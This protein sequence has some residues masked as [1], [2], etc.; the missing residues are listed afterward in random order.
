MQKVIINGRFLSQ[1]VTGVQRYA[2]EI[3]KELDKIAK[4]HDLILAIPCEVNDIPSYKN[5]DIVRIGNLKGTLWEQISFSSFVRKKKAIALNLCNSA[6]LLNPGIVT[7]HDVKIKAYPQFFSSKFRIWYN[8]LF[9]NEAKR[10]KVIITVSEFS[11]KEIGRYYYV[12][13]ENIHVVPNAWQHYTKINFD[14]NTLSRYGLEK[15]KFY[16]AM[17]SLEPNKNFKLIA[18]AAK[19]DSSQLFV[20][21]GSINERIFSNGVGFECPENIKLIGYIS[22]E[23]GKTLMRDSKAFLFPSFYEGFGIPPLE[24]L[25]AGCSSIIVSDIPAMHEIFEDTVMF[26][27][28]LEANYWPCEKKISAEDRKRVLSKYSWVESAKRLIK[29]MDE[30]RK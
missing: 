28:P 2:I 12:K 6:P 7:I 11:K 4:P 5:I 9:N 22:D 26:I 10:A 1:K 3:L 21:A 17:S 18:D 24:A 19:R 27:N 15:G 30:Y 8:V 16:F 29:I 25:S 23:E 14:E 13:S 20:I